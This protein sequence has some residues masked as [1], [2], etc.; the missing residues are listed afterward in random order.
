[1]RLAARC[2]GISPSRTRDLSSAPGRLFR[3]LGSSQAKPPELQLPACGDRTKWQEKP[4]ECW[5]RRTGLHVFCLSKSTLPTERSRRGLL[6]ALL[7]GPDHSVR[8]FPSLCPRPAPGQAVFVFHSQQGL[9]KVVQPARSG[10]CAA[11]HAARR[12]L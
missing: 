6:Q 9:G 5:R 1:M 10:C 12:H 8:A 7:G 11:I 2:V 3:L 4:G